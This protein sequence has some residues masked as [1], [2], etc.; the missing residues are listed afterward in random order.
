MKRLI[1][2]IMIVWCAAPTVYLGACG[3]ADCVWRGWQWSCKAFVTEDRYGVICGKAHGLFAGRS[4]QRANQTLVRWWVGGRRGCTALG[5][6]LPLVMCWDSWAQ[7]CHLTVSWSKCSHGMISYYVGRFQRGLLIL[8]PFS[9]IRRYH[10][11]TSATCRLHWNSI[12]S[13]IWL[14][15]ASDWR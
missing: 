1:A 13:F 11:G 7:G 15:K 6:R 14:M 10:E 3:A 5:R 2:G 4:V 12:P 8:S 9:H